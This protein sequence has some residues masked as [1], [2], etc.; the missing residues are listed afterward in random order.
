MVWCKYRLVNGTA[1]RYIIDGGYFPDDAGNLIGQAENPPA[2]SIITDA[3]LRTH[4]RALALDAPP[5]STIRMND[6]QKDGMANDWMARR[7]AQ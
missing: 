1:P 2:G 7:R 6:S 5:A 3:E 4:V